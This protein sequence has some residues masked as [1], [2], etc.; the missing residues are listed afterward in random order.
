MARVCGS[1]DRHRRVTRRFYRAFKRASMEECQVLARSSKWR[2]LQSR[3]LYPG[4]ADELERSGTAARDPDRTFVDPA[5]ESGN[6][7]A[8]RTDSL[9]MVARWRLVT[10]IHRHSRGRSDCNLTAIS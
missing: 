5:R 2:W 10:P 3:P 9:C 1:L 7:G 4:I 8:R 6:I